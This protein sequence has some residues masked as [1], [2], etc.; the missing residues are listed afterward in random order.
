MRPLVLLFSAAMVVAYTGERIAV[1]QMFGRAGTTNSSSSSSR[2]VSLLD[3]LGSASMGTRYGANA[4]TAGTLQ[5]TERF[6]RSNRQG[7]GFIGVDMRDRRRFI[8]VR[9]A[10]ATGTRPVS[11]SVQIERALPQGQA[12]APA[13]RRAG[14]YEPPLEIGFDYAGPM[15]Q[16]VSVALAQHL[17]SSPALDP[18]NRIEVLVEGT[19]ATLRGEVASE[20]D[21]ALAEQLALFEPGVYAVRNELRIR[22][23]GAETGGWRPSPPA[24]MPK[25]TPQAR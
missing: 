17:R 15:R 6:L 18:A 4:S 7:A 19:T 22:A 20:R 2:G 13:R 5:G 24:R 10:T 9:P 14:M 16:E 12:A 23:P 11:P 8:G 1:A 3:S 25:A 21:R